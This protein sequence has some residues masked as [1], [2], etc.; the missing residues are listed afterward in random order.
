MTVISF[1][2]SYEGYGTCDAW[3]DGIGNFTTLDGHW[4]THDSQA[5][6]KTLHAKKGVHILNIR[7]RAETAKFKLL[8]VK[9]C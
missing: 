2:V 9:S 8:Y 4:E 5:T 3:I 7:P 6:A 1:L